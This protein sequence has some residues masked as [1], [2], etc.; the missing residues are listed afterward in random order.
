MGLA[1]MLLKTFRGEVLGSTPKEGQQ[2]A[3]QVGRGGGTFTRP[4]SEQ[5]GGG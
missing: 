2:G 5:R 1:R 3:A 4:Q